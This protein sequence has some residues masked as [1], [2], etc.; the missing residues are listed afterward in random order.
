MTAL[1]DTV[2][3]VKGFEL[4]AV[5]YITKPFKQEEVLAR[6]KTHLT[7]QQLQK[8]LQ[9]K[10]KELQ[11]ALER[12]RKMMEDLR[13]NLSLSLPHELRTPLTGIIGF[14]E[15]LIDPLNL[16][17]PDRIVNYGKI[18]YE[19]GLRLNRLVEN[20]LLYANLKLLN[21][22]HKDGRRWQSKSSLDVKGFITSVARQIA[23]DA[24]RQED[25]VLEL[26]NAR[27]R[28]LPEN[29]EKILT[30]LLDNAFKFSQTGTSVRV[31]TQIE[32]N[33]CIF[34][35][36][37]QGRGMR[38]EQIGNIGAYMQF[39]RSQHEQQGSGLGLT[40]THLLTQLEGGE[41]SIESVLDQGT[42]VS[43]AFHREL[44]EI[45]TVQS[46]IRNSQSEINTGAHLVEQ[47]IPPLHEELARLD[48]L[49]MIGDIMGIREVIQEIEELDPKYAPFAIKVRNLAKAMKVS[50]I[51][52]IIKQYL[53]EKQ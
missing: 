25:L 40:I 39:D 46:A 38:Q 32:G 3:K 52:R 15:L 31:M 9:V 26:V 28:I 45:D 13:V 16:P 35:V 36:T 12:E 30:E 1:S 18:I 17:K 43:I 5:D 42:T 50:E 37:D 34:R 51:Q 4:G 10:N 27:I 14:A 2:D 24:Q 23:K 44:D 49:A 7:I 41:L 33:Q 11:E 48:D 22:A 6:V 53:E 19:N 29:F 20:S 47:I 21:Y 8:D